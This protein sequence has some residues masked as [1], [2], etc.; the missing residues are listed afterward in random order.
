MVRGALAVPVVPEGSVVRE[1][2]AALVVP[3]GSA[4]REDLAAQV[5]PE[6]SAVREDLAAQG[7][8]VVPQRVLT[9]DKRHGRTPVGRLTFPARARFP[10]M[11]N[12]ATPTEDR[13]ATRTEIRREI[14]PHGPPAA[15]GLPIIDPRRRVALATSGADTA[16]AERM[17]EA[18]AMVRSVVINLAEL[19]NATVTADAPVWA[20]EAAAEVEEAE[21]VEEAAA[22]DVEEAAAVVAVG[23]G[24][25]DDAKPEHKS[26]QSA[27]EPLT[28]WSG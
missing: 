11:G 3:G 6:G 2:L 23:E 13:P 28:I 18:V 24:A 21:V 22:V 25:A 14:R 4:V 12:A 20:A 1:D 7:E 10:T 15:I 5:V 27:Q 9:I 19:R 16:A 8:L 26:T 17:P